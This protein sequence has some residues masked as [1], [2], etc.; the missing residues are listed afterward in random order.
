MFTIAIKAAGERSPLF[1]S[2]LLLG[3]LYV[4]GVAPQFTDDAYLKILSVFLIPVIA[5]GASPSTG[6]MMNT[7]LLM[8]CGLLTAL[9]IK[10]LTLNQKAK[11]ALKRSDVPANRL[12]SL[13]L[14]F[15]IFVFFCTAFV[16]I[17]AV[18]GLP[19]HVDPSIHTPLYYFL[20]FMYVIALL[21]S[22]TGF[23]L[24]FKG[25]SKSKDAPPAPAPLAPVAPPVAPVA[26]SAEPL[27][28]K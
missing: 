10:L 22:V 20:V 24:G 9:L 23:N 19:R 7:E 5:V 6:F 12:L 17:P 21:A 16:V 28:K 1:A 14:Y 26:L 11:E 25:S 27:P 13:M 2:V 8:I 3:C 18:T 15:G 4:L